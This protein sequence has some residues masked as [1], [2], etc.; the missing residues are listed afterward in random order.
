MLTRFLVIQGYDDIVAL[1]L[2]AGAPVGCPV[3]EDSSTPLHKACAGSKAGHLASVKQ[4]LKSGADVHALNKWRET[5]LL[6]AANHGQAG[7]VE[8]LLAN[9]ADPCMCTDT[10]WSP[11]SIAAY[12][13]HDDVVRLLL[14]EG[15]PTEEDDPTLS[16]LLQ[17]ATK[18]LPDTV[19]L[20][21]GHGADHTVTTKKGDTALSILVEQNLIDAAVE[22]VSTHN[23][24]IPRC[25]RDRKKV[26]R[27][28]LLINLRMK[29]LEKEGKKP[30]MQTEDETDDEDFDDSD[31][32][33]D[34]G[35]QSPDGATKKSRGKN[36]KKHMSAEEKA[37]AAEEAL[38]QE[39]AQEDAMAKK[40]EAEANTKRAKKKKRKEQQ[41]QQKMKEEQERH[42]REAKEAEK[43]DRL[44][45]AEEDKLRLERE[46]KLEE[47]REREKQ[48]LMAREKV[49]AAK[50]KERE[51]R[52]RLERERLEKD[53]RERE[54]SEQEERSR[55]EASERRSKAV[56]GK[57]GSQPPASPKPARKGQVAPA[58]NNRRWETTTVGPSASPS[59]AQSALHETP[60]ETAPILPRPASQ[61]C[62]VAPEVVPTTFLSSRSSG[63]ENSSSSVLS[64]LT[65]DSRLLHGSSQLNGFHQFGLG[66]LE[67]PAIA[68]LRRDNVVKMLQRCSQSQTVVDDVVIKRA[69]Y[70]W[71]L[72]AAHS[73]DPCL[74][75]LIP[76]WT[77]TDQLT[78]FFQRQFIAESR[79][80][81]GGPS[82]EALKDAGSSVAAV[83][84]N[85]A[86]GVSDFRHRIEEQLP[87]GWTDAALG[88]SISDGT[89]NGTGAV[90]TVSWSNRS[91]VYVPSIAYKTLRERYTGNTSQFLA[92]AFVA[93]LW[94]DTK[95]LVVADSP[96]DCRLPTATQLSLANELSVTA[97]LWSDPLTAHNS[98]VYW[99]MF[100]DVDALFGGQKAF[101]SGEQ[102]SEEVLARRGGSVSL[103]APFDKMVASR[104]VQHMVDLLD[105][106]TNVPL[107]FAIFLHRESF[108]DVGNGPQPEDMQLLDPRLQEARR[109]YLRRV[110][111][112]P[113]GEHVF[114]YG[115]VG[116]STK[117]CPTASLFVL[118]QNHAAQNLYGLTE[119]ATARIIGS[120]SVAGP[121]TVS[122]PPISFPADHFNDAPL[123]P[124]PRLFN[125]IVAS[126]PDP[127]RPEL[128]SIGGNP[129]SNSFSSGDSMPRGT[130]RGRLFDLVDDDGEEDQTHD[131]DVVSG[132]LN[133]LDVGM[134][135][136][137][138][139]VTSDVD[140]EAISLMGI[141]S[142]PAH[143]FNQK[144]W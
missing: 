141:G 55:R 126:S 82:I 111:V 132:M 46:Q 3:T 124:Q 32:M 11:L 43:R 127:L 122:V 139:H 49:L 119:V 86:R 75:P 143:S 95:Q 15:A 76:S 20:L 114:L 83:C 34:E 90:V 52:E 129:Y 44:R 62:L 35:S 33:E 22:M 39:L 1:L 84:E 6:T 16:A 128:G 112:L 18:G 38:L 9:G 99:G 109:G 13:G 36:G 63:L 120:L 28:R 66:R 137:G 123:T 21:L 134:F 14:E 118:L 121:P 74:D 97:E 23:A 81:G 59:R 25:S 40:T 135:Q 125:G 45:K 108:H 92:A 65:D 85:L 130:R 54:Q 5:P 61:P 57:K 58:P 80:T 136:N 101:G 93:K 91:T 42:A 37:K 102:T 68:L 67:H 142:P 110:E 73:D 131:V 47:E 19:E 89:L 106:A 60:T 26:Q 64:A 10:G 12:K 117:A 88:M 115:D 27:A 29:Q 105:A 116:G 41:R 72:R 94:F 133:S 30:A 100:E 50:R 107:S 8:A 104:Y 103:L 98:N 113:A 4:L 78:A 96:M 48:E 2:R 69:I 51:E 140:I 31:Q 70:R 138:G 144:T 71:V 56:K 87:Q 24:S 53:R 7:A 17:A 79:R 77:D